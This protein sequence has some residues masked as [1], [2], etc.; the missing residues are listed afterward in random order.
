[1]STEDNI[2]AAV[3]LKAAVE[4]VAGQGPVQWGDI[5]DCADYFLAW[6]ESKGER[7]VGVETRV[8]STAPQGV[9][10]PTPASPSPNGV[11]WNCPDCGSG[12]MKERQS[13]ADGSK[14][15]GC[16]NYPTC[17]G[18]RR[19]DGSTSPKARTS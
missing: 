14:F 1:M 6:L 15:F 4:L 3:A 16:K 12:P 9:A 2:R 10:N 18:T 8:A 7:E 19:L 11:T 5:T 17:R 13:K